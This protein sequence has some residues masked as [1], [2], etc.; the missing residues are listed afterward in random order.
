MDPSTYH[1]LLP[2]PPPLLACSMAN[3]VYLEETTMRFNSL[4]D[5]FWNPSRRDDLEDTCLLEFQQ[6]LLEGLESVFAR[7]RLLAHSTDIEPAN[8]GREATLRCLQATLNYYFPLVYS[9]LTLG[10]APTQGPGPSTS[11]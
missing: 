5:I 1:Q 11:P 9:T 6:P 10:A 7:S 2:P 3:N 8:G 4:V